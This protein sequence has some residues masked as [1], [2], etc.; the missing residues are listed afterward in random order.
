MLGTIESLSV[1]I[2]DYKTNAG[3]SGGRQP[4]GKYYAELRR[5]YYLR[6]F[7]LNSY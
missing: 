3:K 1:I 4:P 5:I 6:Y 7:N 2:Y